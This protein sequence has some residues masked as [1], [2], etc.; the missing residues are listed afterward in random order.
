M[1]VGKLVENNNQLLLS[2]NFCK[3]ENSVEEEYYQIL[4]KMEIKAISHN[5]DSLTYNSSNLQIELIFS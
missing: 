3:L 2:Y 5:T 1:P 4:I